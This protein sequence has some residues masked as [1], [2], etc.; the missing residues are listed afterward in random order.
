VCWIGEE[1]L[2]RDSTLLKYRHL[3][4]FNDVC[5]GRTSIGECHQRSH[6]P[7]WEIA[8]LEMF[9]RPITHQAITPCESSN[10]EQFWL[11][12]CDKPM[13]VVTNTFTDAYKNT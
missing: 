10:R 6:A 7:S 11:M 9:D 4:C 12:F 3:S 5:L 8:R 2:C 13:H 1:G